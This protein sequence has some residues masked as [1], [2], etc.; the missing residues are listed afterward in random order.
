MVENVFSSLLTLNL[1]VFHE[2]K[3]F[4]LLKVHFFF[5][6][7]NFSVLKALGLFN[8]RSLAQRAC[9]AE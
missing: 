3:L 7:A 9:L 6:S 5:I 8:F 4:L 1:F 2:D